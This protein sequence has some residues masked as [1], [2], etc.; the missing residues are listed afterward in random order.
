M[1]EI[2]FFIVVR[3][4]KKHTQPYFDWS[5]Y[6][7]ALITYHMMEEELFQQPVNCKQESRYV[8]TFSLDTVPE[9]I[10]SC[11]EEALSEYVNENL[12]NSS[13]LVSE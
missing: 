10:S 7:Q 8:K 2:C 5:D 6:R 4:L 3:G 9:N 11:S 13:Q 12:E 1:N